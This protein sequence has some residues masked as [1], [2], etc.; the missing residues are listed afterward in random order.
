M[1]ILCVPSDLV[2]LLAQDRH[3]TLVQIAGSIQLCH[4]LTDPRLF[5]G[6]RLDLLRQLLPLLLHIVDRLVP[7]D[8]FLQSSP[9]LIAE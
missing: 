4:V 3:I 6:N 9:G 1:D 8:H 5:L 2:F 7:L